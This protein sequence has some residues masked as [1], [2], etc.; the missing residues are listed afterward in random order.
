M[1][2]TFTDGGV[3][4]WPFTTLPR[5]ARSATTFPSECD[6]RLRAVGGAPGRGARHRPDRR[7]DRSRARRDSDSTSS[8]STRRPNDRDRRTSSARSRRSHRRSQRRS[9][10]PTSWSS[11]CRSVTSRRSRSRRST[12]CAD[13]HRRRL[14]EGARG[15]RDRRGARPTRAPRFVGG[16]PMAGSEQDGVDGADADLFVGAAWVL[17][18]TASTD[19]TAF[20]A[21]RARRRPARRRGD[22]GRRPN[23]TTRSSRS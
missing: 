8:A 13:R 18:P 11:R 14:G 3:P 1:T 16:H 4:R 15:R 23:T 17:T 7:L 19:P 12:R 9:T 2:T 6:S 20:T 22:R 5:R 21:V 10:A